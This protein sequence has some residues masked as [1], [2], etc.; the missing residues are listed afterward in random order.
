[1]CFIHKTRTQD[2]IQEEHAPNH[3]N[4]LLLINLFLAIKLFF[5]LIH[6]LSYTYI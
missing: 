4:P 1:M 6:N 5:L 3:F 2:C